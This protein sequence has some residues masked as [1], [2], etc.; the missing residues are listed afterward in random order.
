[1]HNAK[2][3]SYL[4]FHLIVFIW[5][6]TA[7]LGAL[8]SIDSV[9]LVFFR[10]GLASIFIYAYIKIK[11]IDL[12]VSTK[13]F[14]G[15]AIAGIIIALHWLTFFGAI[16]VANVSVT[17]ACMSTGAF[18]TALL[19]PL[20]YKRK[21][22]WY[23]LLFGLIVVAALYMIFE[24][25]PEYQLG[26]GL[27]LIS[28][29]LSAIFTLINGRFV[30]KH[31]P[32]KISFYELLIGTVFILGYL[33]FAKADSFFSKEFF[34]LS[35]TDWIYIGI[36]ASICTA[37]A[38]IASVKVMQHLSP[39]TIMLTINLEPVYGILLAFLVLGDSEKMQP[40]FYYGA[41]IILAV[42]LANGI[43][44]NKDIFVKKKS[45]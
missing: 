20:F 4:H 38:F 15:F 11:G 37:Y 35:T 7:V 19:E 25:Q 14:W 12:S 36:L 26:I 44:K 21:F 30:H 39:Y 10:M 23:E 8:I 5:G 6:F 9:P 3:G 31:N 18:F 43:L 41:L 22:I 45:N 17:L 2:L 34:S 1:M 24:V 16:K 42:V 13:T 40:T 33:A 27:A 32:T 29:F 28:A